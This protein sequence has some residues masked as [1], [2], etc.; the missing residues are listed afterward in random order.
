M[1]AP[2]P[3]APP[4]PPP[5]T[6]DFPAASVQLLRDADPSSA[7]A[8]LPDGGASA[9][10]S[11]YVLDILSPADVAAFLTEAWRVLEPGGRLCL[12]NLGEGCDFKS[13]VGSAVWGAVHAVAPTVRG[14]GVGVGLGAGVD[15]SL[16]RCCPL[17]IPHLSIDG[18]HQV[19]GGCR[20]QRL[21][22][23]LGPGWDVL[24]HEAVPGGWI[25]SEVIVAAK[26]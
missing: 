9:V 19:V 3:P 5:K 23:Y 26:R 11:T 17:I 4:P 14:V 16:D 2:P 20:A 8:A 7:G 13:R 18:F 12:A 21:L 1:T 25:A 6:Q 22:D 10:L 15:S 24:H